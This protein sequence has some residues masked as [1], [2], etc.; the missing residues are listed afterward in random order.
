MTEALT[1]LNVQDWTEIAF[2]QQ[3]SHEDDEA[4]AGLDVEVPLV[5]DELKEQQ[6]GSS[7]YRNRVKSHLHEPRPLVAAYDSRYFYF[8][9]HFSSATYGLYRSEPACLVVLNLSFQKK[10]KS[11]SRF[12]GA[13]VDIEFRDA[14]LVPRATA[15][16]DSD[17]EDEDDDLQP[18]VLDFE[19]RLYYGPVDVE[20]GSANAKAKLGL[21]PPG[22]I[23]EM[24]IELGREFHFPEEGFF[25]AHGTLRDNPPSRVH[26]SLTENELRRNGIREEISVALIVRYIP[27]RRFSARI[28]VRADLFLNLLTPVCGEK[29]EPVYF[30]PAFMMASKNNDTTASNRSR[31]VPGVEGNL[32]DVKLLP[33]L[34]RLGQYGGVFIKEMDP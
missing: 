25:K 34:T 19:P 10:R 21:T 14:L 31:T 13:E 4:E 23:A 7:E 24:G 5:I 12:R 3:T 26:L 18:T 29:D 9:V 15:I 27:E 11:P 8:H 17:E 30:D 28:T 6:L 32:E 33:K 2:E 16:E 20:K 1:T 22:G